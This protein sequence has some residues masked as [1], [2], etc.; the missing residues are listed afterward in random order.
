MKIQIKVLIDLKIYLM[1]IIA[2]SII[3]GGLKIKL[4]FK[5]YNQNYLQLVLGIF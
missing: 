4:S 1:V 2:S 3:A 5:L